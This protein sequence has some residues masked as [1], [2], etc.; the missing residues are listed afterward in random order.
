MLP[1]LPLHYSNLDFHYGNSKHYSISM[2]IENILKLNSSSQ[3]TPTHESINGM[4]QTNSED[5]PMSIMKPLLTSISGRNY[6][7][8]FQNMASNLI[9]EIPK[10]AMIQVQPQGDDVA[11]DLEV[12][13]SNDI[14][15]LRKKFNLGQ[16]QFS[17]TE[18]NSCAHVIPTFFSDRG[19][20]CETK[21]SENSPT[22]ASSKNKRVKSILKTS[23]DLNQE[24]KPKKNLTFTSDILFERA[25]D[26]R[27]WRKEQKELIYAR[28]RKIQEALRKLREMFDEVESD[29][30]EGN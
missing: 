20:R 25:K 18:K 30:E 11:L 9:L 29:S 26:G 5:H 27:T 21:S 28:R 8:V 1:T 15:P 10:P 12:E 16:R 24:T 3:N 2:P 17:L 22:Q 14:T 19:L 6:R 13:S 7:K 23:D 4:S